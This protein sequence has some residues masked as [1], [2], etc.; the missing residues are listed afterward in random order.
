MTGKEQVLNVLRRQKDEGSSDQ[1]SEQVRS[2]WIQQVHS[3]IQ[4]IEQWLKPAREEE[5]IVTELFKV[6]VAEEFLGAPYECPGLRIRTPKGQRIEIAPHAR[7]V[8]GYHGRIDLISGPKRAM[9]LQTSPNQWSVGNRVFGK[10]NLTDLTE[11]TF[12][13]LIH[14]LLI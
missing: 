6:P 4:Q 2:E 1:D 9:L 11:E 7:L 13:E 12:W 10:L 8:L 14:E 5:L 3:L